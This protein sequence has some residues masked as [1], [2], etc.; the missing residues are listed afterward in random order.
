MTLIAS[1]MRYWQPKHNELCDIFLDTIGY[2][3]CFTT[4]DAITYNLPIVTMPGD[5]MKSRQSYGILKMIDVLDTVA[6]TETEYV[7][8]AI[9]L[10]QDPQLRQDIKN[11]IAN[12]KLTLFDDR[13]CIDS[14][15][16]FYRSVVNTEH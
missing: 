15:E 12:K 5:L 13:R 6:Y 14:L 10:G 8:I 4:V 2:S 9:A 3:G 7:D 11:K 16:Q 1:D